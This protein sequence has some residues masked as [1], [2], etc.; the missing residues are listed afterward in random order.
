[1][2]CPFAGESRWGCL[3]SLGRRLLP[4]RF[5]RYSLPGHGPRDV[6]LIAVKKWLEF[7]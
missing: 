3:L 1:M 6:M 5:F 2:Y 7:I 4:R